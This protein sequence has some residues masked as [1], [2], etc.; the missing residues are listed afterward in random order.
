MNYFQY[1][2]KIPGEQYS[3]RHAVTKFLDNISDRNYDSIVSFCRNN[4]CNLEMCIFKVRMNE[5]NLV[6]KR[7][8]KLKLR[9]IIRRMQKERKRDWSDTEEE[10]EPPRKIRRIDDTKIKGITLYTGKSGR[11]GMDRS[12]WHKMTDDIKDFVKEYN[13]AISHEEDV[14][15]IKIPT[16]VKIQK[17][18]RTKKS[19]DDKKDE[20]NTGENSGDKKRTSKKKKITFNLDGESDTEQE[21]EV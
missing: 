16:N 8:N 20:V 15:A 10:S 17:T 2:E 14:S 6:R 21:I 7:T 9:G 11:I 1:L 19:S 4:N 5:R 3:P 18:R 13:A 12:E